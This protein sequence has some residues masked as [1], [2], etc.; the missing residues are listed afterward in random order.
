MD[1][2]CQMTTAEIGQSKK[3]YRRANAAASAVRAISQW[4]LEMS[5]VAS[6]VALIRGQAVV[7]SGIPTGVAIPRRNGKFIARS[8][9]KP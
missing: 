9:L 5:P 4:P 3:V 6:V 8:R 2:H 7:I 1:R